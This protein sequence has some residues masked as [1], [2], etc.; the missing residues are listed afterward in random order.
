VICFHIARLLIWLS[1]AVNQ[2]V[3]ENALLFGQLSDLAGLCGDGEDLV[4]RA[5]AFVEIDRLAVFGPESGRDVAVEVAAEFLPLAAPLSW[6]DRADVHPVV[7][8]VC[9]IV[10]G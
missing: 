4:G 6:L 9:E 1:G 5:P 7:M 3:G 2:S 10:R 8:E